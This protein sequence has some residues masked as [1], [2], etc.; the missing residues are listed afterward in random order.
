MKID[1]SLK[2]IQ[3]LILGHTRELII[4]TAAIGSK[5]A[6]SNIGIVVGIESPKLENC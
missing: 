1:P 2:K 6:G 4:Q 5:L 3:V